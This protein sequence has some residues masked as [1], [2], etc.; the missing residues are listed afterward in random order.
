MKYTGVCPKCS[1]AQIIRIEG[2]VGPYGTG[3]NI[4]IGMTIFS[5]VKVQRYVCLHCGF[6]EEWIDRADLSKL[7][8]KFR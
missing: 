3:N 4:P 8:Q 1:G 7:E 6:S 5:A 2:K